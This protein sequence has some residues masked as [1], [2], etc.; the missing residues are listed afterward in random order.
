MAWAGW[1]GDLSYN[2]PRLG[3]L[4]FGWQRSY[5]FEDRI[6]TTDFGANGFTLRYDR[7][8]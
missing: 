3:R 1:T 4:T 2:F 7:N 8:F 5:Y 6:R